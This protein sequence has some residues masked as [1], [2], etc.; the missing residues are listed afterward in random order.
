M[1]AVA[2]VGE[3]AGG[4][5]G[6]LQ[7]NYQAQVAEMNARIA[8]QNAIRA[9]Q[10]GTIDMQLKDMDTAQL[11]GEQLT[12]QA[13]SGVSVSG[14]SQIRTR[15]AARWYGAVDRQQI[16][17]NAALEKHNYLVDA[18]NYRAEA[19]NARIS[20]ASAMIGGVTAAAGTIGQAMA[21]GQSLMGGASSTA[22]ASGGVAPPRPVPRPMSL[23]PIG[24]SL[25]RR[26]AY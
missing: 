4:T 5:L 16:K 23:P 26:R 20:G 19:K 22:A 17:E 21:S 11:L 18:T 13:A 24:N 3:L 1:A 10:Q 25:L 7:E 2:A 12:Q 8:K 14:E 6:M 9:Q 15:N